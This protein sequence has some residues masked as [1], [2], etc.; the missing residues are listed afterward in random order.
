MSIEKGNAKIEI[1]IIIVQKK[2]RFV[3]SPEM[4][5]AA[6]TACRRRKKVVT[7]IWDEYQCKGPTRAGEQV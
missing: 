2:W 3:E 1:T 7:S 6:W 5:L 4:T